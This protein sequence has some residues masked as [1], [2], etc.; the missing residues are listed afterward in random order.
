MNPTP[1]ILIV[2]DTPKNIQILGTVLRQQQYQIYVAQNGLQ[3]L[4]VANKVIPDLILLDIMMPEMDGFQACTELKKSALTQ[5][6]PVIFLTAKA[7]AEDI[8]KGF[9]LG[10][11]DYV[12]K[13]FNSSELLARVKT[14]LEL[15][16]K[17]RELAQSAQEQKELLHI[18]CHDLAN[19]LAACSGASEILD[20]ENYEVL[21]DIIH[22]AAQNGLEIIKLVRQMRAVEDKPISLAVVKVSEAIYQSKMI[23]QPKFAAKNI[24]LVSQ[25]DPELRVC[26]EPIS[27][28]NSVLNNLLTNAI[29]FSHVNSKITITAEPVAQHIKLTIQ[30]QGMGMPKILIGKLFDVSQPTSRKGTQGEE[31]TGFGMPLVKK[32]VTAYHGTITVDSIDERENATE[33]GTCITLML[34][35]TH[36]LGQHLG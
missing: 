24:E 3:A 6:I 30:D 5:K 4:E 19:P 21:K 1:K 27:F 35:K 10:A 17:N 9:E 12:L 20:E 7:E 33:H 15:V 18:L 26:V 25:V 31:G 14:H 28:I 13:P 22:S 34:P 36:H 16:A 29:K 11:V 8:V 32:F 2:D 23:L